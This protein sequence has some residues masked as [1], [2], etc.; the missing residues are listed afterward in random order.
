MYFVI[1]FCSCECYQNKGA[2]IG[3]SFKREREMYFVITFITVKLTQCF[4]RTFHFEV[5]N[6]LTLIQ[7]VYLTR[8]DFEVNNIL[9]LCCV[10]GFF[11]F[12]FLPPASCMP[13]I[14]SFSGLF[15]LD[16]PFSFL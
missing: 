15:I 5:N 2:K 1:I 4:F 13:N 8:F 7:N 10:C 9:G 12:F 14:V 3:K 16:F 6:I 11:G